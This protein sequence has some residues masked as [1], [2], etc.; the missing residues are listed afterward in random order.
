MSDELVSGTPAG[1][2]TPVSAT[3]AT[4]ATPAA[5]VTATPSTGTPST[6]ATPAS[7]GE[8]WVPSYRLR[9]AREAAAR[10]AKADAQREVAA[11]RAEKE[12]YEAQVRALVGVQKPQNSEADQIKQQFFQLF[13]WAQKLEQRFG[14]LESLFDKANDLETSTN[15][16][17]QS[18]GKQTMDRL[19]TLASDSFG[20]PLTEEG[21]RALHSSFVG[22]VQSSPELTQRYAN[23][24]TIV[25]DFWETFTKSFVDPARR[26]SQ[27]T[28]ATRGSA[29][30]RLPVDTPSGAPQV[31][32][33]PKPAN[34]DERAAVAFARYNELSK[35]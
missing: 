19:F 22:W 9:E 12:R 20:S 32:Q 1:G 24:P 13:P 27:A 10:E 23:D 35:G 4:P 8:N 11:I 30:A 28:L 33:A 29:I 17:W 5:P 7:P 3:P 25:Q 6:P 31:S 21:K 15:H 14:D 34:L 18:Y 2:D 26:A 16:Y